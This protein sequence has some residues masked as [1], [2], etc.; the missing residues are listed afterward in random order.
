MNG[1]NT[2]FSSVYLDIN[3]TIEEPFWTK[4]I[5]KAQ[6]TGSH[7]YA[8]VDSNALSPIWGSP[9]PHSRGLSLEDFIY[10]HSLLLLN[11]GNKPTFEI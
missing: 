7:H 4:T 9:T 5:Q 1:K 6:T 10:A 8:G 2:Y 3:R 11:T